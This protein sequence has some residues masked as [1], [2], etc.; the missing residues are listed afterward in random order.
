MRSIKKIYFIL[1]SVIL[2]TG[3]CIE[4]QNVAPVS[5]GGVLVSIDETSGNFLGLPEATGF[6]PLDVALDYELYVPNGLE[7]GITSYTIM[8]KYNTHVM[9]VIEEEEVATPLSSEWVDIETVTA[10]PYMLS[11]TTEDEFYAGFGIG[12]DTLKVGDTF[13]FGVKILK[14]DGTIIYP[15]TTY[16]LFTITV[17]CLSDLAGTYDLVITRDDGSVYDRPGEIIT[18]TSPG[19]YAT[20]LTGGWT[21]GAYLPDQGF[22]FEDV[23]GELTVPEQGLFHDYYSNLV[24]GGGFVNPGTGVITIVHT[25]DFSAGPSTYTNVYTPV[26]SKNASVE[27]YTPNENSLPRGSKIPKADFNN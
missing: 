1:A 12:S 19:K 11:Y 26:A 20:T 4:P 14:D 16:G 9:E 17:N 7:S 13:D 27:Y 6:V 10:L 5:E 18:E 23:C 8:K 22:D 15:S 3:A 25:I 2:L 21:P 24:V